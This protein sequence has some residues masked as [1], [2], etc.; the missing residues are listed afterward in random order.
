[1]GPG[2]SFLTRKDAAD[3]LDG[4]GALLAPSVIFC[5][6]S[7]LISRIHSSLFSDWRCTFS[8]KF[9]DTQVPSISTKELV[10]PRHARCVFSRLR[11]NGRSLLL[12]FYLSRIG[13]IGNPSCSACGHP[14]RDTF[15]LILHCPDTGSLRCPLFGNFYLCTNSGPGPEE[16]P[17][18]WGSMVFRHAPIPRKGLGNN[19]SN[20]KMKLKQMNS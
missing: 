7:P 19:N 16:L 1:M 10:L 13:K 11:C 6:L 4:L 20:K 14:S 17:G 5:S 3:E 12:S 9:F 15:H 8:S 18:F 2:Q